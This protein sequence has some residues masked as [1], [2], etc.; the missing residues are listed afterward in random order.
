MPLEFD[1]SVFG[2]W[3]LAVFQV[4][5]GSMHAVHRQGSLDQVKVAM[6]THF[7]ARIWND[8]KENCEILAFTHTLFKTAQPYTLDTPVTHFL[9]NWSP[10]VRTEQA[11]E[12]GGASSIQQ[13]IAA[14]EALGTWRAP[15]LEGREA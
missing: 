6:V 14:L 3:M 11:L 15:Y 13:A 8:N 7:V 10:R 4:Y 2:I 9:G 12:L 1:D 5:G